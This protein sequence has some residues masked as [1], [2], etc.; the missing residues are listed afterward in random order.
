M[1]RISRSVLYRCP[2]PVLL[3]VGDYASREINV[4]AFVFP[5]DETGVELEMEKLDGQEVMEKA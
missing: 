1:M 3:I 2:E 4:R 5:R